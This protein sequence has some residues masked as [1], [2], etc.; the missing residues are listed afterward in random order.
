M[1]GTETTPH[2]QRHRGEP[3][4]MR[5]T[6]VATF[7]LRA[8]VRSLPVLPVRPTRPA[9]G[10]QEALRPQRAQTLMRATDPRRRLVKMIRTPV[11]TCREARL[12][13]PTPMPAMIWQELRPSSLRR[14]A[15]PM[16]VM[17]GPVSR[18]RPEVIRTRVTTCPGQP[19]RRVTPTRAT[20]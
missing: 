17:I 1:L 6:R 8:K 7:S 20:I 18:R 3:I 4:R 16:L 2:R 11:M 5:V 10:R 12:P 19:L 15:T 13:K 9:A 14:K